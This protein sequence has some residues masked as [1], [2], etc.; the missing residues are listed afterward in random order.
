VAPILI[1]YAIWCALFLC[2]E[3]V[4]GLKI[5]LAKMEFVPMGNVNNVDGLASIMVCGVSFLPI[6]YLGLP[7]GALIRP[8]L[9]GTVLLRR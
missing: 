8:N 2:F 9:F 6:K 5:N 4:S 7:L 1:I 3:I